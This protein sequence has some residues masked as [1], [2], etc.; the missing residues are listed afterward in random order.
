MLRSATPLNCGF[1]RV[2]AIYNQKKQKTLKNTCT[3]SYLCLFTCFLFHGS[4]RITIIF[5]HFLFLIFVEL[6][7]HTNITP[8][9]SVFKRELRLQ[10]FMHIFFKKKYYI[11]FFKKIITRH[12]PWSHSRKPTNIPLPDIRPLDSSFA[13]F[14]KKS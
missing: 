7:S 11:I 13:T 5:V 2:N 3:F 10:K 8:N 12:L 4:C 14:K 1:V 6:T 9:P